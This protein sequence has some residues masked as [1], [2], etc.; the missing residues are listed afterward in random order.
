MTNLYPPVLE[1]KA[2]AIPY[3]ENPLGT[4]FYRIIFK[5]PDINTLTDIGH[6][7][8][9]IKY[10]DNNESAVHPDYSPDGQV[11]YINRKEGAAFFIGL[12]RGYYELRIPY[13]VFAGGRPL[14]GVTYCVQVRFGAN[15]L[16]TTKTGID[17]RD[18]GGFAYWRGI[19]TSMVPS[20][21]GE[22]SNVQT[23]YC[24]GAAA[25]SLTVNFNDFIPE[26]E[27][28]YQPEL[29]DPLE[30]VKIVYQYADMHGSSFKTLVFNG[31]Y[32]QD[33][34]YTIRA[35]IPIAP[36]QRIYV[37]LEAVTK[38][39]TLRGKTL[40]IYP[41]KYSKA[42]PV[43]G[44]TME[45][46][47][48]IGEE[49]GDGCL[50]KTM[51]ITGTLEPMSTV[52]IYRCNVYTLEVIKI[53]EG[54]IASN[55][56]KITFKDYS[57]EMGED[58]QYVAALKNADGK[59]Y[60]LVTDIY[61]WGYSNPGY[62]RLMK[63]ESTYLTTRNHQL[64]FTGNVNVSGF[65]RVTAD[66]F[67]TTLGSKYPFYSRPA[68]TNY[69]TFQLN[70]LVSIIFDPTASFLRNDYQNGL[71]WDDDKGSYLTI[72]NR[73]L[74][75]ETQ[76]SL[77]RRRLGE[78]RDSLSQ[79]TAQLGEV[80]EEE[81]FNPDHDP[82]EKRYLEDRYR[83]VM[84]PKTIYDEYLHRDI[85]R[86]GTADKTDENVYLER[87]F[88]EYVMLWLSDG[89]P[90]LFRS[91]T[92]GNMIVMITN[93][94]FTPFDKSSRMV[95]SVSCTVTEIAEYNLDNLINYD[96]LPFS[97][98][99][100]LITGLPR[101]LNLGDA[102]DR[103]DYISL[104]GVDDRI[105]NYFVQ[106]G[107]DY[108]LISDAD[109]VNEVI[110]S[111]TEYTFIR[112]DE[113]P[114][115]FS[116]LV[117]QYS[118][119]YNIPNS[120]SGVQ[121]KEINLIPAIKGGSNPANYEFNVVEGQLPP[122][123]SLGNDGIIKGAPIW[124][125]DAAQRDKDNITIQVIDKG[126]SPIEE[127]TMTISV[128]YIY[129][130]L[131]FDPFIPEDFAVPGGLVGQPIQPINIFRQ[132][133]AEGD[134][135]RIRGGLKFTQVVDGDGVV[136]GDTPY[137]FAFENFPKGITINDNGIISGA[138]TDNV[139]NTVGKITAI[140]AA[141]QA[142]ERTINF[143]E[144]TYP[145]YFFHSTAFNIPYTEVTVPLEPEIDVS[146]GVSGG[147][148]KFED[149]YI[150]GYKFSSKDL[151]EGLVIDEKTG[152]ISGTPV[153]EGNAT[154]A[155]ITATDFDDPAQSAS[156]QIMVQRRLPKF[157]FEDRTWF[158]ISNDGKPMNLGH[159]IAPKKVYYFGEKLADGTT[160][161]LSNA[162]VWGG[163]PYVNPPYYRFSSENLIPDFMIDNHGRITGRA[164]VA[165][166]PRI[167]YLKVFDARGKKLEVPIN[168]AEIST[169]LTFN[170]DHGPYSLPDTFV[171]SNLDSYRVEIPFSDIKGGQGEYSVTFENLPAGMIGRIHTDELSQAKTIIIE[172]DS[173]STDW[174]SAPRAAS[175]II[176]YIGDESE[177]QQVV[178]VKIPTGS[179]VARLVWNLQASVVEEEYDD[180]GYPKEIEKVFLSQFSGGKYPFTIRVVSGEL[181]PF[182]IRQTEGAEQ[183]AN[184]MYIGGKGDGTNRPPSEVVFEVTDAMGQTQRQSILRQGTT[185]T[186]CLDFE[187]NFR[188]KELVLG[189]SVV[190]QT[191]IATA[192]GGD[193]APYTIFM[194][195]PDG[196]KNFTICPGIT[197]NDQGSISGSP[198]AIVTSANLS[199]NFRVTDKSFGF[200]GR[201]GAWSR[202]GTEWWSPEVAYP[203]RLLPNVTPIVN[204]PTLTMDT[205]YSF[206]FFDVTTHSRVQYSI[207][208]GRLSPGLQLNPS[209]GQIQGRTMG[210][211]DAYSIVIEGRIPASQNDFLDHDVVCTVTVNI[212]GV[213]GV[214]SYTA[215]PADI[216]LGALQVGVAI[217]PLRVSD[218]LK[219]GAKEF[220]WTLSGDQIGLKVEPDPNDSRIAYITG[221]PTTQ[222]GAGLVR[223][224]VKDRAGQNRFIDISFW[225]V[226]NPLIF[227][228][229]ARLDIPPQMSNKD[230][231]PIDIKAL[232]L[233]SGGSGNYA[234]KAD[235]NL[236]PYSITEGV[237]SGNSGTISYPQRTCEITVVDTQTL[238]ESKVAITVGAITGEINYIN[239]PSI[240]AGNINT[241]VA[242]LNI[243]P[244]IVGGAQPQWSISSLPALWADNGGT[245]TIDPA[246]A[247]I[248]GTRPNK[249]T[250]AS[251]LSIKIIDAGS[252]SSQ[253]VTATIPVGAVIGSPISYDNDPLRV[254][255]PLPR[256]QT[257]TLDIS[258][259]VINKIAPQYSI[260]TLPAGWTAAQL[261]INATTGIISYTTPNAAVAAGQVTI[262]VVDSGQ[263]LDFNVPV[264][265][266]S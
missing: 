45:N 61:E 126:Q 240:P 36:V 8:I 6:I 184:L 10:K 123:L 138:Y 194:V 37:S 64:R 202:Q 24:Y 30:Q 266:V 137:A 158:D 146:T 121:I 75:G 241:A 106:Q 173:T 209:T 141:G 1:T 255:P 76:F 32:Q 15:V 188:N 73:D 99:T 115:A 41:L 92:E 257:G 226:Y 154:T 181:A 33:G 55:I 35:K 84:G 251:V 68:E 119:R 70:G 169:N 258:K 196:S 207:I 148:P 65:K 212:G 69:R 124:E 90:K 161:D 3:L 87:K 150:H 9:S 131:K 193:G 229:D 94:S 142:I 54:L 31:Q 168:I 183:D 49:I 78:G 105:K 182:E 85:V 238:V 236:A 125:N 89:K 237:I 51:Q 157:C 107:T 4:D 122:G 34:T 53:V 239:G 77:S 140:D 205:D 261:T 174:P 263:T 57:P 167:A 17:H 259:G 2:Q 133:L 220:T 151:P 16:W 249:N 178:K 159:V 217:T 91:E 176:M 104:V 232:N 153:S 199:G 200:T 256:N 63:M 130:A 243:R 12:E 111:I 210:P 191:T 103:Q 13:Y 58:Y 113:D 29:D 242:P 219:G 208:Q 19:Q 109:I 42:L 265:A 235:N 82:L 180:L 118:K 230:I 252:P 250:M 74:Y 224:N 192:K 81:V 5:M 80:L 198:T 160:V 102:I 38:N 22:W 110:N 156:I 132:G 204:L 116:G 93:A 48:L 211:S 166:E 117:F 216:T 215:I 195:N 206:S 47:P 155:T 43:I 233:V 108:I 218:G 222:R 14:K 147:K 139:V 101:N 67:Q 248:T 27:Y 18:F 100:T 129:S 95:Y 11:I 112:G 197:L 149:G 185:S 96:L 114:Y 143:G 97:I 190:P 86:Q 144:G 254:I 7:Q 39:N 227:K 223:V 165:S 244:N 66:Q 40:N 228:D 88:R 225:G 26:L 136:S 187:N 62:A 253:P 170:G 179:I 44:G 145:V 83:N 189:H 262:R 28:I 175:N 23:V 177:P 120:I 152:I 21:F 246:T 134:P 260:L 247:V 79:R 20:G 72:L 234:F 171:G 203:P 213:S 231:T 163:L 25:T 127:A 221:I 50:A 71:W 201:I 56:N 172:R 46:A 245:L 214:M 60:G 52:S 128:G 264:G 135:D 162:D 186:L 164:Q 59:V 98:Q